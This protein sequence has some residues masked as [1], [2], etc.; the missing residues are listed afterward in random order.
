MGQCIAGV[1]MQS[2]SEVL[3]DKIL[4]RHSLPVSMN[5]NPDA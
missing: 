1:L 4:P 5:E 2:D 3:Q